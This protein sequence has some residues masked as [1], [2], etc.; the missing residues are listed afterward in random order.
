MSFALSSSEF[1]SE[2][3]GT[4]GLVKLSWLEKLLVGI[5]S[6]LFISVFALTCLSLRPVVCGKGWVFT[7]CRR[8][9]VIKNDVIR[10]IPQTL[11]A[12]IKKLFSFYIDKKVVINLVEKINRLYDYLKK[13]KRV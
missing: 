9:V 2:S 6:K 8:K 7:S 12:Q 4:W 13:K 10:C 5:F 3:P 11:L 1:L